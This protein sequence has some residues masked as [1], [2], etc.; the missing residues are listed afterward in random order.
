MSPGH[1][2]NN[3]TNSNTYRLPCQEYSLQNFPWKKQESQVI[4]ASKPTATETEHTRK[5]LNA[6]NVSMTSVVSAPDCQSSS[7]CS[8][9][10]DILM[11]IKWNYELIRP[12]W[13]YCETWSH[14]IT[15]KEYITGIWEQDT[16]EIWGLDEATRGQR[17]IMQSFEMCT[18]QKILGWSNWGWDRWVM[19]QV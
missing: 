3:V 2:Y 10:A 18:P 19:L 1:G 13:Y 9:W 7:P 11:R 5:S 17:N 16:K 12:D 8:F 4:Q 6:K 14:L 15:Q